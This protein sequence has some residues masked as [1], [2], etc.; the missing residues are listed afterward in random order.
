VT[1]LLLLSGFACLAAGGKFGS[2]R[3]ANLARVLTGVGIAPLATGDSKR[4]G[5]LLATARMADVVDAHV[6]LLV[7]PGDMLFTSDPGDLNA[8]T[9]ARGISANVLAV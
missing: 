9:G 4:I 8:L 5:E 1:L 2:S 6:A 3:Q 7:D